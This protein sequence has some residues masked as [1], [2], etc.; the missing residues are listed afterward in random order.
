MIDDNYR[1]EVIA[2]HKERAE[3]FFQKQI[4]H[5]SEIT[6]YADVT[7]H[8]ILF[9]VPKKSEVVNKF[10]NKVKAFKEV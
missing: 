2:W 8:L 6:R 1:D 3:A 5:L 4:K 10:V 9:P 7:F